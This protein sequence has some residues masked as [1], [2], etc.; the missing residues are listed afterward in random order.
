MLDD[1]KQRAIICVYIINFLSFVQLPKKIISVDAISQWRAKIQKSTIPNMRGKYQTGKIH[2][3]VLWISKTH[4][5]ILPVWYFLVMLITIFIR[6]N[7][8]DGVLLV[9]MGNIW[10]RLLQLGT[11]QDN[12]VVYKVCTTYRV[13]ILAK[14]LSI[15][16]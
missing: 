12:F 13:N 7:V 11:F 16:S 15:N 9:K 10:C 4:L 6:W 5:W 1:N 14:V 2:K 3:W 8:N